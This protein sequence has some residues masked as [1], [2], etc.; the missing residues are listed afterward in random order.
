MAD[1]PSPRGASSPPAAAAPPP[2]R[3]LW[4]LAQTGDAAGVRAAL[5]SGGA[6]AIDADDGTEG[7]TALCHACAQGHEE[8]VRT[9]LRH[10]AALEVADARGQT[11]LLW[12]VTQGHSRVAQLLL[13]RGAKP[14]AATTVG[15]TAFHLACKVV[16]RNVFNPEGMDMLKALVE[17]GVDTSK[18]NSNGFTGAEFLAG[19]G[20]HGAQWLA[21]LQRLLPQTDGSGETAVAAAATAPSGGSALPWVAELEGVVA[22]PPA[23][24]SPRPAARHSA[25]PSTSATVGA[26][27]API[28]VLLSYRT[29][30][31]SSFAA[32]LQRGL[33]TLGISVTTVAQSRQ[34]SVQ[35][36]AVA[37][38]AA[39]D[40]RTALGWTKGIGDLLYAAEKAAAAAATAAADATAAAAAAAAAAGEAAGAAGGA[41]ARDG[42]SKPDRHAQPETVIRSILSKPPP[43]L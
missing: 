1:D 14:E 5:A 25:P 26:E 43:P 31:L 32:K 9:L 33:Q 28:H 2:E 19:A 13:R 35:V 3:V 6:A 34:R 36:G 41:S 37:A 22:A 10:G 15:N 4:R 12:A 7:V 38:A 20:A 39:V 16:C 8:V 42:V 18:K 40:G 11:P 29:D 23:L 30:E 21:Q 24:A 27:Q 17:A